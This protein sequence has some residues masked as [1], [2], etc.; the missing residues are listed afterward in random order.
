MKNLGPE[1][2][3]TIDLLMN[4]SLQVVLAMPLQLDVIRAIASLFQSLSKMSNNNPNPNRIEYIVS[5]PS[6]SQLFE[7]LFTISGPQSQCPQSM[8]CS[9]LNADGLMYIYRALGSL[10]VRS[11][12]D[13]FMQVR[14]N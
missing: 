8:S 9:P 7:S 14:V 1:F 3:S 10:T 13:T 2:N 6:L 5:N 11:S 4:A 12:S